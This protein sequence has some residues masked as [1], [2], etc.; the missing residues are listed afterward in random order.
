M[1]DTAEMDTG[2]DNCLQTTYFAHV[3]SGHDRG[4]TP[5]MSGRDMSCAV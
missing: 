1:A 2:A 3:H 4:L 5:V